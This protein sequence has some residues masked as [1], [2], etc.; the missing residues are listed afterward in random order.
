MLFKLLTYGTLLAASASL[1]AQT[2]TPNEK[3]FGKNKGGDPDADLEAFPTAPEGF[4]VTLAAKEPVVRNPCSMVFDSQGR[5]F[6]GQGPQYRRY[7]RD[8]PKDSVHLLLDKDKDGQYDATHVFATGFNAIQSIAWKGNDLYVANA[9]DLTIVRDL[10]GDDVAD[11]YVKLYTDLGN[12]E[13][14][15]HGLN[16]APDGRLYLSKGNSKGLSLP[17]RVAPK[18]FR[19]L[20]DVQAPEGSSDIPPAQ[21]YTAESY[22][23]CERS[24]TGP[25]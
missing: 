11:E 7:N 17:G 20:W 22:E 23:S 8:T 2:Y 12:L 16:F 5:L 21:V 25:I 15:L 13:H 18:A 10:N 4:E 9:P 24:R 3:L 1:G 14:G 19:E 6:V